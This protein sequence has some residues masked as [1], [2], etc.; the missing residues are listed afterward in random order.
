MSQSRA[1]FRPDVRAL[2]VPGH[3]RDSTAGSAG[4][5]GA[6]APRRSEHTDCWRLGWKR[7]ENVR[8]QHALHPARPTPPADTAQPWLAG[9][10]RSHTASKAA[11]SGAGRR[12]RPGSSQA[13][14]P[15]EP[16]RR[17]T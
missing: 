6:S 10:R 3:V 5:E 14:T 17:E 4:E 9:P 15:K 13:E 12:P 2:E 7:G 8:A 16:E 11:E 1:C